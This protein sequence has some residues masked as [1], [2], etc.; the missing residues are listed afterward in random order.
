MTPRTGRPQQDDPPLVRLSASI[1]P[2]QM[3][4]LEREAAKKYAGNVS[5]LVREILAAWM[6][7]GGK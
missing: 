7:K 1:T 5:Y 3:A 2:A 6:K 4:A